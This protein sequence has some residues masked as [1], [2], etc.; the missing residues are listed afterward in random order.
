MRIYDPRLGRFLS[1]DPLASEFPWY[2]PYQFAGNKP[3]MAVDLDGLEDQQAITVTEEKKGTVLR[4]AWKEGNG[5]VV[6]MVRGEGMSTKIFNIVRSLGWLNLI[7]QV[8]SSPSTSPQD[9]AKESYPR[10]GGTPLE[11]KFWER[12]IGPGR[13]FPLPPTNSE[14]RAQWLADYWPEGLPINL[15]NPVNVPQVET[16]P[17]DDEGDKD[18]GYIT[19]YRGVGDDVNPKTIYDLAKKGI[20]YPRGLLPGHSPVFDA[21]D[22]TAGLTESIYTSWTTSAKQAEYFARGPMGTA[23]GVILSKRFKK[24][25][26]VRSSYA[27][28]MQEGEYLVP[29]VVTG[30]STDNVPKINLK[31]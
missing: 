11:D 8:F 25:Q 17:V 12:W 24:S 30:A 3:I 22:H 9:V 14:E 1:V 18:D 15:P 4:V 27:E 26:L 28:L 29:G 31:R 16:K 21:D 13:N 23:E 7:R 6:Q 5:K 20:A 10:L 19:L 2:T